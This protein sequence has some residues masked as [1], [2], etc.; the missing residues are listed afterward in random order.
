MHEKDLDRMIESSL[1]S[2]GDPATHL[3]ADSGLAERILAR[4]SSEQSSNHSRTQRAQS[5]SAL[6]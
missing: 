2:Y 6:G 1:S 5:L 3:G 4:V